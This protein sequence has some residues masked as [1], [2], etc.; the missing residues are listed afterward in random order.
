MAISWRSF[1]AEAIFVFG[2]T[3]G[4]HAPGRSDRLAL[5]IGP[6]QNHSGLGNPQADKSVQ[7]KT[8][9]IGGKTFDKGVGTHADSVLYIDLKRGVTHFAAQVGVDDEIASN[10]EPALVFRVCGDDRKLWESP[11]M[12][13]HD[14]PQSVDVDLTGM[15]TL[16]L[17]VYA[18]TGNLNSAHADWADAKLT[19]NGEMPV[20]FAIPSEEPGMLTPTP[21]PNPESTGPKFTA[22]GPGIPSF[23]AF[24]AP[25]LGR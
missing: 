22:S 19:V 25:A 12:H 8:L 15:K 11:V 1:F 21:R 9:A 13:A 4:L 7:G 2:L 24:P 3:C 6:E 20:T 14:A 17:Y 23:T 18:P 5:R 16:L 10:S